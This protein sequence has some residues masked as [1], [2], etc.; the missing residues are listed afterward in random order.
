MVFKII[1]DIKCAL[2]FQSFIKEEPFTGEEENSNAEKNNFE[3]P[4]VK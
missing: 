4:E 2:P 3:P 1:L